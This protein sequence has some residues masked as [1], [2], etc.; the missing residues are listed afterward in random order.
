MLVHQ[1]HAPTSRE[2]SKEEEVIRRLASR[3]HERE[4]LSTGEAIEQ[5]LPFV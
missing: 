2:K 5:S 4:P 3:G 1:R